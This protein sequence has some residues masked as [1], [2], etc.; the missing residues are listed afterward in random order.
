MDTTSWAANTDGHHHSDSA[1]QPLATGHAGTGSGRSSINRPATLGRPVPPSIGH[2]RAP[3]MLST[4][5]GDHQYNS[6]GSSR[7]RVAAAPSQSAQS[8][9]HSQTLLGPAGASAGTPVGSSRSGDIESDERLDAVSPLPGSSR[10]PSAVPFPPPML[11]PEATHTATAIAAAAVAPASAAGLGGDGDKAVGGSAWFAETDNDGDSVRGAS[12]R[13]NPGGG[14]GSAAVT[15]PGSTAARPTLSV[16][17]SGGGGGSGG[18][19]GREP[20]QA[21]LEAATGGG[22]QPRPSR[23]VGGVSRQLHQAHGGVLERK[24]STTTTAAGTS[25]RGSFAGSAVAPA[26]K[27]EDKDRLRRLTL[28]TQQ[29]PLPRWIDTTRERRFLARALQISVDAVTLSSLMSTVSA[30]DFHS[31]ALAESGISLLCFTALLTMVT[32]GA[33]I[34]VYLFPSQ[35]GIQPHRHPRFSRI[36]L[37]LDVACISIWLAS[38]FSVAAFGHRCPSPFFG[39]GNGQQQQQ[40]QRGPRCVAWDATIILSFLA[41]VAQGLTAGMGVA[42]LRKH[43]WGVQY[44][45][46]RTGVLAGAKGTWM[47]AAP[48]AKAGSGARGGGKGMKAAAAAAARTARLASES[49]DEF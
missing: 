44:H 38:A 8:Q 46:F 20:S 35:L 6:G 40:P 19:F 41:A 47:P 32:S 14:G 39:G 16:V 48:S 30:A 34:V 4:G 24:A 49:E 42:D 43:A 21:S 37:G 1:Q 36:E 28:L 26:G 45:G 33:F 5:S 31:A 25:A 7:L 22:T 9:Q 18:G 17:T 2:S 27:N 15:R 29:T 13:G 10:R 3:S 23:T 11:L 12:V